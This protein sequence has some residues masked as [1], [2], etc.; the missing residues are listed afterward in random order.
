MKGVQVIVT[1]NLQCNSLSQI[2]SSV[3]LQT[4]N[5]MTGI[6]GRSAD[7]SLAEIQ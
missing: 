5:S 2:N 1:V 3:F 7:K 4:E 6:H